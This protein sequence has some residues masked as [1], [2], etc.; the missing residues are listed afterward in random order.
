MTNLTAPPYDTIRLSAFGLLLSRL[1]GQSFGGQHTFLRVR[2]NASVT[3]DND[4]SAM[5]R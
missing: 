2:V 4:D 1:L 3:R 5:E